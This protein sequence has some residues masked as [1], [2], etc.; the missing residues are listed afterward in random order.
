MNDIFVRRLLQSVPKDS[1]V[2]KGSTPVL[3]FGKPK[4]RGI[5]TV[6]LN[7]SGNEF[8]KD[9]VFLKGASQRFL[10]CDGN[11]SEDQC[12]EAI[13]LCENYFRN[14]PYRQWFNWLETGALTSVGASF[15][16]ASACHLDIV[17]WAT[18]PVWGDL[19][20][21][22]KNQL[23][24]EDRWFFQEM[25]NQF[26]FKLLLLNGRTTFE[27]FRKVCGIGDGFEER[28]LGGLTVWRG[29]DPQRELKFVGWSKPLDKPI[30]AADREQLKL[31]LSRLAKR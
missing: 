5:A 21:A 6:S 29:Y 16:D 30:P 23:I 15:Y 28:Q 31:F 2:L 20:P 11:L 25:V 14:N 13:C 24:A 8:C 4:E 19:S 3:F 22:E 18:Q 1:R 10:T 17:Q 12:A 26:R 9:G 27:A 7:P